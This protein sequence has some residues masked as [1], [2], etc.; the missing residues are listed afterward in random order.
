MLGDVLDD[1]LAHPTGKILDEVV[2]ILKLAVACLHENPQLRLT[3][4]D[5]SCNNTN[6]PYTERQIEG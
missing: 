2:T 3:M 5:I 4:H 1:C 6:L